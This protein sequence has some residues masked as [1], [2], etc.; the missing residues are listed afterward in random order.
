MCPPPPRA[1]ALSGPKEPG[2]DLEEL[3][4]RKRPRRR[5][6]GSLGMSRER[7]LRHP[8]PSLPALRPSPSTPGGL[9]R[10]PR[11]T[12]TP[13]RARR[14]C[15]S[16]ASRGSQGP[17]CSTG[18]GRRGVRSRIRH[19]GDTP[20]TR[21]IRTTVVLASVLFLVPRDQHAVPPAECPLLS[22]PSGSAPHCSSHRSC[23]LAQLPPPLPC[24]EAG[25]RAGVVAWVL[26]I[27]HWPRR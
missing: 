18:P 14:T 16:T 21:Y 27:A 23:S 5:A 1:S 19:A 3:Q 2:P 22:L 20:R 13:P 25:D 9:D 8:Q 6:P 15:P 10:I 12:P 7:A 26:I 24:S 17:R 4:L 11:P